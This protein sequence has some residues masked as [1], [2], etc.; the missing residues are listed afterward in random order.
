MGTGATETAETHFADREVHKSEV[1]LVSTIPF[2]IFLVT[3]KGTCKILSLHVPGFLRNRAN[4]PLFDI[5]LD[6]LVTG[7]D[8]IM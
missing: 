8:V 7:Y 1:L 5:Q 3:S 4:G 6:S 2:G